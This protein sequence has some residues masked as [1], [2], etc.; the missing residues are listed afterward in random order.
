MKTVA[1][2]IFRATLNSIEPHLIHIVLCVT[3]YFCWLIRLVKIRS[4]PHIWH[5]RAW[6]RRPWPRTIVAFSLLFCFNSILLQNVHPNSYPSFQNSSPISRVLSPIAFTWIILFSALDHPSISLSLF[7]LIVCIRFL[8]SISVASLLLFP[9]LP[10]IANH[11][12]STVCWQL[13]NGYWINCIKKKQFDEFSSVIPH[14]HS[15]QE[16]YSD[17]SPLV[18]LDSSLVNSLH[19]NLFV[20]LQGVRITRFSNDARHWWVDTDHCLHEFTVTQFLSTCTG[21][22]PESMPFM[23]CPKHLIFRDG[24]KIRPNSY[25]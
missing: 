16:F 5:W 10:L 13:S 8:S 23:N 22:R 11:L 14:S 17:L 2:V 3:D 12:H 7:V 6:Q 24:F 1:T 21:I 15:I 20:A 25:Q 9:P 18:F 4:S 19:S